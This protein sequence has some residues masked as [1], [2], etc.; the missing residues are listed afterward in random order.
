MKKMM[1]GIIISILLIYNICMAQTYFN[2]VNPTEDTIECTL[3]LVSKSLSEP[4]AKIAI[5]PH[6]TITK[7]FNNDLSVFIV[8]WT[9]KVIRSTEEIMYQYTIVIS[10]SIKEIVLLPS[11]VRFK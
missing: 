11:K 10:E 1:F 6:E 8:K 2:F 4:Y 5:E 3:Y 9:K 7:E